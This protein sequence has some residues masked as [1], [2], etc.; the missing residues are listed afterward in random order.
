[1]AKMTKYQ[2]EHFQE[3]IRRN[4]DPLIDEQ[5]LLVKQY[6]TEATN[7]ASKK[8]AIKIGAQ[9][10]IDALKFAEEDLKRAQTLAQSF[11]EKKATTKGMK[12]DLKSKFDKKGYRYDDDS[13][14][15][16]LSDCEDQIRTWAKTLAEREIE[17]RPEGKQ[18]ARLKEIKRSA[19]DTIMESEAPATLIETLNKHM[20][21][22][23]GVSWHE[24]PRAIAH[25]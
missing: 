3:K 25:N 6:T 21:K 8:L 12:E 5:E 17:K 16:T 9:K 4:L 20:T 10:I 18:L 14:K 15:I 2:L 7:R 11:F 1:M 23:L 24:Q 19:L 13:D 22:Y